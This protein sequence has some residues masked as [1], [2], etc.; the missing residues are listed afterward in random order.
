[1]MPANIVKVKG[2]MPIF[3]ASPWTDL[4]NSVGGVGVLTTLFIFLVI[5]FFSKRAAL[6]YTNFL[7]FITVR[8]LI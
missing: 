2:K 7:F 5:T 3:H 1:M 8:L 6:I 4:E